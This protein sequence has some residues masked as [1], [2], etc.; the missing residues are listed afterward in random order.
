[1]PQLAPPLDYLHA[2]SR[3][4][5]L[6]IVNA[7]HQ[8]EEYQFA[9]QAAM[10]WL[11][12]YPGDL[13]VQH[14]QAL[15]MS[16]L[17]KT[18]Q[19]V[20]LFEGLLEQDPQ[21]V[22]P[23]KAL[24]EI[25]QNK[26]KRQRHQEIIQY[27]TMANPPSELKQK[28]LT[29]LWD[30]RNEI[31][32][33]KFE[34]ATALIHQSLVKN[35]TSPIPAIL[36]LKLAYKMQNQ[37][38]LANLS[39]IYYEKY[40]KCLQINII[41]AISEI[42]QG[43][44][45]AAVERLHWAA[46]HDSAGQVITRL[47]GNDHRFKNL[48]PETMEVHFDLPIPASVS[49]YLGWN[50]LQSGAMTTPDFKQAGN[51][52]NISPKVDEDTREIR[53]VQT[54]QPIAPKTK[55]SVAQV[56][57][58]PAQHKSYATPED[59][60]EIQKSFSKLAK[61]LKQP[62]LE[63]ADNRF[64]VYVIMSSKKQ[65]Q[66]TYGVNTTAVINNHL[67]DMA[68]LIQQLPDWGARVFLPDDAE[69]MAKLGL[70]P[71]IASDA[72]QVKLALTDLDLALAKNGE[73]IGALL[74]VGG[75][76]II[77]FHHL[78]NPTQDNDLDVP[79]DNPYATIDE[80]Y[81]IPQ[82]P[83][84][85]LPGEKGT[86]SGLLLSQI[87]NLIYQYENK[88]KQA[89]SGGLNLANL[90]SWVLYLFSN[91]GRG[92]NNKENLGYSAEIWQEPSSNVYKTLGKA[93]D[94]Q[95]SPPK[96][97]GTLVLNNKSAH[98]LGYFNL[99][100]VKDGP[101]WYGQ[102]DFTSNA[103]GPDYPIA[104][105]P[106]M[107]NERIPSPK[108]VLTEACY[109]ANVFDKAHDEAMALKF[110]DTGTISFIGSTCIAY[111]SVTLPLI[112]ADYLADKFWEQIMEGQPA[113][114]ALMRAKLDLAEEM[115]LT[116]GFLD[117]ED[118]K[119]L[120]SF[121]LYGDPLAV[122]DGHQAMPKPLARLK[123]HPTLKTISDAE[124]EPSDGETQMPK[125]LDKEVRNIVEKYLPGLHH[126]QMNINKSISEYEPKSGSKSKSARYMV[127]LQ[128]SIDQDQSTTHYHYARM[129][130]NRKG[131]LIK[132]TTSR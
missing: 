49:S 126:S 27:L 109:G 76:G 9:K 30:A 61:R 73:M 96:D 90:V 66:K 48:W 69:Q 31:S 94:L 14:L 132:F 39:E 129:T 46:A 55:K 10:L 25:L 13:Y 104:L 101:H 59:F 111:G 24:T 97:T 8:C 4:Q 23:A 130:F 44:E 112:S 45:S 34:A 85:R 50:Q 20:E 18:N 47:M 105:S 43:Q 124:M 71:R 103:V 99:H 42:D 70:K 29:P 72:W 87:R 74:I 122:Y 91:I 84:G 110:L 119:T 19:S 56:E 114:Y 15:T 68:S 1:M 6:T 123:S 107:F 86:D 12:N 28:W 81:F 22:E 115:T 64:P 7:A 82:W 58:L 54:D 80:N 33:G 52:K 92:L 125:N 36:H 3:Y 88:S 98:K 51:L 117:G 62:D 40:P 118:Q 16:K 89:K 60:E 38:M 65:L 17:N 116:Q 5:F 120:L 108:F 128:K 83:V 77:P 41:K 21:F 11:V 57:Q 2:L 113:G 37:E 26:D 127:T 78:P 95:L 106:S 67:Q 79:S 131:K 75:P 102:K 121:V 32:A 53:I 100:G 35:P 63:R 93:K